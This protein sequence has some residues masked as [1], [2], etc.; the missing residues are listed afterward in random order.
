[1]D[2]KELYASL[3][4]HLK[5]NHYPPVH[6]DFI[7][8]AIEAINNIEFDGIDYTGMD[9]DITLPNNKTVK[10]SEVIEGLHLDYY[11]DNDDNMDEIYE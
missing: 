7:D 4:H 11:I 5:Y 2:E 9:K 3:H 6:S 8:S 10:T 1:M